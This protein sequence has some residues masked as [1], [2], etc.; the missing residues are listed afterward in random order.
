M[1]EFV[2]KGLW[3]V[4]EFLDGNV[5]QRRKIDA[6]LALKGKTFSEFFMPNGVSHELAHFVFCLYVMYAKVRY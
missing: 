1:K 2:D 5:P 6:L 3:D 4:L